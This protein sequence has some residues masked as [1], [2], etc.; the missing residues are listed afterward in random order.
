MNVLGGQI[1]E[2]VGIYARALL[3]GLQRVLDEAA[4]GV[5][6]DARARQPLAVRQAGAHVRLKQPAIKTE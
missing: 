4:F 6:Q 1:V 5:R 3:Y 2:V